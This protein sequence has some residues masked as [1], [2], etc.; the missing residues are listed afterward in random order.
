VTTGKDFAVVLKDT[1]N[2]IGSC[3]VYPDKN[4]D[5]GELGWILHKNY[6]KHGYGT[7]LGGELIRF[8]FETLKLRRLTAPCAAINY[9]S[10]RLMERNGMRREALHIKAFWARIDKEWINEARYVILAEEYGL[11]EGE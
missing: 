4:N 10:C 9:G 7:E 8:G 2:V 3:G 1:G 5:T 11:S 6:W